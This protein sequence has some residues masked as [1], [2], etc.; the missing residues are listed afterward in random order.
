M[1]ED[2]SGILDEHVKDK[3]ASSKPPR[4]SKFTKKGKVS[5][6]ISKGNTSRKAPSKISRGRKESAKETGRDSRYSNRFGDIQA[7]NKETTSD[8]NASGNGNDSNTHS[9][10]R[11]L[12]QSQ[13]SFNKS[14]VVG[15]A[16]NRNSKMSRS[17]ANGFNRPNSRG[18]RASKISRK[19][20]KNTSVR[21]SG[22]SS[23]NGG[24]SEH[25]LGLNNADVI[26]QS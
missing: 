25:S 26:S 22:V 3:K 15:E 14:K 16:S 10:A 2:K 20:R 23:R 1:K 19:S 6:A 17:E 4:K 7:K 11:S 8:L 12:H 18:S 21:N 5:S 13:N 9:Y 24:G